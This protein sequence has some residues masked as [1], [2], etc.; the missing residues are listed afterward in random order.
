ME[1]TR[2]NY[3]SAEAE[4]EFMGSSS[5][6]A[7]DNEHTGFK[8]FDNFVEGGCEAREI[9]VV[10]GEYVKPDKEVFLVGSYVHAWSDSPEAFQELIN[11]EYERI[12]TKGGKKLRAPFERADLMIEVL[13]NSE[14]V[15]DMRNCQ[16][17]QIFTGVI[18]GQKI[19]IQVD[20][21]DLERGY[22]A[23]LKTT[24]DIEKVSYVDGERKTF[25]D[26]YDYQL[27]FAMYSEIIYQNIGRYL[28]FYIIVVDKKPI[29]NHEVIYMGNQETSSIV[30]EKLE[31]IHLK[32]PHIQDVRAR[33]V[34]PVGCGKCAYCMSKK[35]L[36]APV[37]YSEFRERLGLE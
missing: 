16:H 25:I 19:K 29:P 37:S 14:L 17:E 11:E 22:F 5:F 1:L 13:K 32:M 23:D 35:V 12:Y 2:K 4:A 18:A 36:T 9:A 27:Q 21:M 30:A 20:L 15:T 6:K 34:E 10:D 31:E 3:F 8:V 26:M 28:D 33:K 7:Y 24:Q